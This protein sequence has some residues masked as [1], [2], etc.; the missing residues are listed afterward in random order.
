MGILAVL[1]LDTHTL[2]WWVDGSAKLSATAA[3]VI[4][5]YMRQPD[6]L[7]VSSISIWE[8]TLLSRKGRLQLN[9]PLHEWLDL[10]EQLPVIRFVPVDNVVA[11]LSV[12]LPGEFHPDPADRMIV[13]TAITHDAQLLTCDRKILQYQHVKTLW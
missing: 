7:L 11:R 9:R 10:V 4:K 3:E 6:S 5:P 12:E 13:A 8:I 2:V 1:I